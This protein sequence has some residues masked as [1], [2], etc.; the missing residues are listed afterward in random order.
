MYY[1]SYDTSEISAIEALFVSVF[2]RSENQKEGELVGKLSKELMTSTDE[3][4]VYGFVALDRERLVGA[5]FLSRLTFE[6]DIEVFILSPVA[7]HS[8]YQGRGIGQ[9]L[10]NHGLQEMKSRKVKIVTT[11]GDPAF[12][13]KVGFKPLPV[14][15]IGAPYELS[16]P[17]GWLGQSLAGETIEAIPGRC[18]CVKALSN[19]ALW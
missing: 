18:S 19:P 17:E 9:E 7:I 6:E 3:Q 1:R 4:D 12:Y 5:I 14:E 16:Q 15:V 8:D 11:Y 2:S 10:I 13:K